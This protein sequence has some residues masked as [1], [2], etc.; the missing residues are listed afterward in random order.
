[1]A[2]PKKSALPLLLAK[3]LIQDGRAD[4]AYSVLAALPQAV[5]G[6]A[7]VERLRTHLELILAVR[8]ADPESDVA[9]RLNDT[10]DCSEIRF[11]LAAAHLMAADYTAALAQLTEL[12]RR[13]T[14]FRGS[15][16]RRALGM[17][18]DLLSP[19]DE[20]TRR[21]RQILFDY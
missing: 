6:D 11:A 8:N 7:R 13:D 14:N 16:R 3:L 15:L 19:E 21:Y 10:P 12:H 18:L 9:A 17:V 20:R 1:M 4:D 2:E 5:F